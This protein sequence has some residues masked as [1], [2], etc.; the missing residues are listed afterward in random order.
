PW[1]RRGSLLH[2]LL[3]VGNVAWRSDRGDLHRVAAVVGA[4][5]A[6]EYRGAFH[7]QAHR[8]RQFDRDHVADLQPAQFAQ[9]DLAPR[10]RTG[11][12]D[13]GVQQLLAHRPGPAFV[14]FDAVALQAGVEL[15]ADRLEHRVGDRDVEL[16]AT[17]L[18]FDVE[19]ADHDVFPRADDVGEVRVD[20][21]VEVLVLDRHDRRPRLGEVGE[22]LLEQQLDHAHFGRGELTPLD[23]GVVLARNAEEAVD[24][25]VY[26]PRNV[27]SLC[28]ATDRS[29]LRNVCVGRHMQGMDA[30]AEVH[31]VGAAPGLVGGA[32]QQVAP[33]EPPGAD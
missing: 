20:L 25:T 23:A 11:Q 29:Q 16:A 26:V 19:A 7:L 5:P 12:L 28:R 27:K 6:G 15:F 4:E 31:Q 13:R 18:E 17:A 24:L 32:A 3:E 14:A 33:T 21:G 30:L 10:Q 8:L 9:G 1:C 2:E 22:G